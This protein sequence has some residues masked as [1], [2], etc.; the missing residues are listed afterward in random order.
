MFRKFPRKYSNFTSSFN[1]TNQQF[2]SFR[3]CQHYFFAF[4]EILRK[5]R[6]YKKT[7]LFS[8]NFL[9]LNLFWYIEDFQISFSLCKFAIPFWLSFLHTLSSIIFPTGNACVPAAES[10]PCKIHLRTNFAITQRFFKTFWFFSYLVK[11]YFIVYRVYKNY[12]FLSFKTFSLY[13]HNAKSKKCTLLRIFWKCRPMLI[14]ESW[15]MC[16]IWLKNSWHYF[17]LFMT[18]FLVS[19][20][21]IYSL[22]LMFDKSQSV[23]LHLIYLTMQK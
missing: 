12:N 1:Y 13:S 16:M 6:K 7:F 22:W 19:I 2:T 11:G 23:I 10:P 21:D 20:F 8:L 9:Q 18:S 3:K 14:S 17:P 4:Q 15:T 5:C